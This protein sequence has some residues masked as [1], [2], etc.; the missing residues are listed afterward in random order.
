VAQFGSENFNGTTGTELSA[1]NA[2]W[3]EHGS[4]TQDYLIA[5]A[6]RAY[7]N[8]S[9]GGCYYHSGSPASADYTVSA[10]LFMRTTNAGSAA[11]GVC[12]RIDTSADTMYY[13]RYAG[14]ATD[15]WQLFK[16]VSGSSTQLGSTSTQAL[17][18]ETGYAILL[19]MV[20]T[21]IE[22]YK[23]GA[24]TPEIS[25]T[26]SAIS[27]AG[28]AGIRG[29]GTESSTAGAHIDDFSADDVGG[30]ATDL[31]IQEATHAHTADSPTLTVDSTLAIQDATHAHSADS[32][33]VSLGYVDL[34]IADA[35]HAHTADNL[36]ISVS[37]AT[38]LTIQD[39][40]HG[41]SAD[42]LT[43]TV[44][45][46]TDLAI[47][48]A[49]HAHTADSLALT[50]T[51][52]VES[53]GG[54][55]KARAGRVRWQDYDVPL[56][57]PALLPV[58]PEAKITPDPQ[59]APPSKLA[60]LSALATRPKAKPAAPMQVAAAPAVVA[61]APVARAVEA[62]AA[63]SPAA[64]ETPAPMRRPMMLSD[65]LAAESMNSAELLQAIKVLARLQAG[66]ELKRSTPRKLIRTTAR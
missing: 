33:T 19:S 58:P 14:G 5:V 13:A 32:L 30:G 57:E 18:D 29:S 9:G 48:D 11:V 21:T 26:D 38:D 52:D 24:G 7:R 42:N 66:P 2:A 23:E 61:P 20:G 60:P 25:T 65:I 39:A 63:P 56:P 17:T 6:G 36:T 43:L 51:G 47:Q 54:G 59:A 27:S 64:V 3:T 35:T 46:S 40:T 31:T 55:K 10:E 44:E 37:G 49:T 41:H 4:Y 34:A 15:G 12:G 50:I 8:G 45:G 62:A 1:H 53:L 22:L 28:K 16:T